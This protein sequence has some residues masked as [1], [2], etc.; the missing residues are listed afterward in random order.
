MKM[1]ISLA[2]VLSTSFLVADP[3]TDADKHQADYIKTQSV[4]S[5]GLY[6]HNLALCFGTESTVD[7]QACRNA[8]AYRQSYLKTMRPSDLKKYS[9]ELEFCLDK[10]KKR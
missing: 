9:D 6:T 10:N 3:C 7:M 2:L 4:T 1:I 5:L 8:E